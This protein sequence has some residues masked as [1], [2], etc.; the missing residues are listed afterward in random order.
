MET[1]PTGGAVG[2]YQPDG[3]ETAEMAARPTGGLVRVTD[4]YGEPE[5]GIGVDDNGDGFVIP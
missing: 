2:V 1:S 3:T 5:A 4:K